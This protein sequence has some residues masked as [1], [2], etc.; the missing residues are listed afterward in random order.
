[1]HAF[2]MNP[3]PFCRFNP[4]IPARRAG[5]M[6]ETEYLQ[7]AAAYLEGQLD[8]VK[9]SWKALVRKIAFS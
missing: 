3:Y 6:N 7:S 4:D 8:I 5:Q 1:M 2:G 9:S